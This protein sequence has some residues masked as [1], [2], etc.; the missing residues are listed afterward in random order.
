LDSSDLPE[1]PERPG[2]FIGLDAYEPRDPLV[3]GLAVSAEIGPEGEVGADPFSFVA[4]DYDDTLDD[5]E[6]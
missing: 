6:W 1:N 3:F 2:T 4:E 5:R